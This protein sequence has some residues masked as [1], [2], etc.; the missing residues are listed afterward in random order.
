MKRKSTV[1]LG[2][3]LSTVIMAGVL[4][5]CGS[6]GSTAV[7]EGTATTSASD[8]ADSADSSTN[9]EQTT[10]TLM[11]VGSSDE[12][13]YVDVIDGLVEKFNS[14]NTYN[15]EIKTEWYENEQYKTK[16]ATLMTQN[17]QGDIFFSWA[18][19]WLQPYVE[20]GKVYCL[21]DV[22]NEDTEWKDRFYSGVLDGLTVDGKVYAVPSTQTV[23]A[24]Y[25]SKEIFSKYGLSVP[26]T[27]DEFTEVSQTLIDN[28]IAPMAMGGQDS[29]VVG[30]NMLLFQDG[31][32]GKA[33]YDDIVSGK[34]TWTDDR[35]VET[36]ELFQE[37]SNKGY[38]NDGYLGTDYNGGRE[39]FISG[40]AAMYPMGTWD[41]SAVLSGFN[42]DSSK[43]GVFFMPAKNEENANTTVGQIDKIY[44]I[45]ET[46]KNKEAA[47]A[48]LKML[49]D[50]ET[51]AQFVEQIGASPV[52][53]ASYSE[54]KLD[55][56]TK[57]ILGKLSGLKTT[58]PMN[59]QFGTT[60]GEEYNNISVSIAGGADVK[61]EFQ[62]LQDYADSEAE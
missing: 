51:Q 29:W 57:E 4:G 44:A 18:A 14:E 50:P 23:C 1:I 3:C 28:G 54:D 25:Y 37:L 20:N 9:Q 7:S 35:F 6:S 46:C 45:S 61:E 40:K 36:G 30:Y 38:F 58:L 47:C 27:W 16:L 11:S 62:A 39:V 22:L 43:V 52:A 19:G 49:S 32:G 10:L 34:T 2:L 55:D 24:V 26:K 17:E 21:S 15:V 8:S 33:L 31:V 53:D 41:T 13:N 56:L 60:T 12:Q 42:N 59:I 48:F 5:G